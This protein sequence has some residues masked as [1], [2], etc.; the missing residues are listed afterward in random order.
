[1]TRQWSFYLR[2]TE[3]HSLIGSESVASIGI[4]LLYIVG[5]MDNA[6]GKDLYTLYSHA[7]KIAQQLFLLLTKF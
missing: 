5:K 4:Y 6:N 7:V 2:G 1:M 3:S